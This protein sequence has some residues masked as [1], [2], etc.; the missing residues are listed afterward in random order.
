[1]AITKLEE[2]KHI[3]GIEDTDTSKDNLIN[4]L[5]GP[6]EEFVFMHTNNSFEIF[7]QDFYIEANKISFKK[8]EK[9]INNPDGGFVANGLKTGTSIRVSGSFLNDG[10]YRTKEVTETD[11]ELESDQDIEDEAADSNCFIRITMMRLPKGV[12]VFIA[13]FIQ[14][15]FSNNKSSEGIASESFGGYSVSYITED[16]IPDTLL[17]ILQPYRRLP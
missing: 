11:I 14:H 2:I 16:K 10:A 13:K 15:L 4:S 5:V 1:M 3:L 12:K 17:A 9:K 8:A 7:E 6:S